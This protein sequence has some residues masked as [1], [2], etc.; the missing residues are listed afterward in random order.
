MNKTKDCGCVVDTLN[1]AVENY[2]ERHQEEHDRWV[3]DVK[4]EVM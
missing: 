1:Q 4:K 3:E 2:C